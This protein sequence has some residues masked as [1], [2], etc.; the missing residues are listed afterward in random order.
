M[1]A[2]VYVRVR[3]PK[4]RGERTLQVQGQVQHER[5]KRRRCQ[6]CRDNAFRGRTHALAGDTNKRGPLPKVP[7]TARPG[8]PEKVAVLEAR[9]KAGE[10][11]NHPLDVG[12]RV[13]ASGAAMAILCVKEE[14]A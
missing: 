3:C 14:E 6:S 8:T 13:K 2:G 10:Q 12:A 5:V 7:T 11:L 9:V 4:C 1:G